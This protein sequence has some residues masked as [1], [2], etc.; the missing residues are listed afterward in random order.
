MII[1]EEPEFRYKFIQ[2][3]SAVD[4][5]VDPLPGKKVKVILEGEPS[6]ENL[7]ETFQDFLVACG[8]YLAENESLAIIKHTNA[9]SEEEDNPEEE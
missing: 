2:K 8:F 4:S 5:L 3:S 7:L 1:R 9:E 6:L